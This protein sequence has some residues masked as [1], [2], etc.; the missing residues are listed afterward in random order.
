MMHDYFVNTTT[1]CN[2]GVCLPPL[3]QMWNSMFKTVLHSLLWSKLEDPQSLTLFIP[4]V[5]SME[6]M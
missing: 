6:K 4:L 5:L 2:K 3:N 1:S